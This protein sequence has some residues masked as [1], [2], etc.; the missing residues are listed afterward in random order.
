[1]EKAILISET[2]DQIKC[3]F[4]P[5]S[6][7]FAKQNKWEPA[8]N[9]GVLDAPTLS[10]VSGGSATI[11]FDLTL[12]TTDTGQ[13]VTQETDKLLN[14]MKVDPKFHPPRPPSCH[15]SWGNYQSFD[16]VL[17]SLDIK[18]TYFA[19]NGTAL[20]A[21]AK[22][23]LQ[24]AQDHTEALQ[25]P[26]SGTPRPHRVHHSVP[27]ETLDRVAWRHYGDSTQWRLLAE[28]NGIVDPLALEPGCPLIVPEIEGTRS[29]Q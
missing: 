25:N 23:A 1:V 8:Q 12:D 10:F 2:G 16:A 3:Q 19:S 14:L 4:N 13:A 29:A 5:A 24:Q 20:R 18:Y 17:T 15:L 27:G 21:Q 6:F 7:S 22:L 9:K 26:T 11:T 28:A